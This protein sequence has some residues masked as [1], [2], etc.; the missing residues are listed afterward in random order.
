[1][2]ATHLIIHGR[3]HGV[4]YRDWTV[5]TAREL[6]LAGWV[7]NLPDGTVEAHLEGE[8]QAVGAM[9]ALMHD[10]PPAAR[11]D[12]IEQSEVAAEGLDRFV[13]R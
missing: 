7:R 13:R 2:P 4:F 12:R 3:V 1:M 8:A 5:R 11:V 10:G 6:G 9:I